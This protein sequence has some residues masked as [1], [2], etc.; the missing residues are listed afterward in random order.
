MHMEA[1]SGRHNF[2]ARCA[3]RTPPPRH[4]FHLRRRS[5]W[6][7]ARTVRAADH[8]GMYSAR[9]SAGVSAAF[10]NGASN[11]TSHVAPSLARRAS[12]CAQNSRITE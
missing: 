1:L 9:A 4:F 2:K 6:Y 5:S 10:R 8:P 7:G 12:F 3:E 11:T